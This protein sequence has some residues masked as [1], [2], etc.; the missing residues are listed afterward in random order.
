M[1]ARTWALGLVCSFTG[2]SAVGTTACSSA[3]RPEA[4]DAGTQPVSSTGGSSSGGSGTRSTS[5]GGSSTR[6][7]NSGGSNALSAGGDVTAG[8]ATAACTATSAVDA[9]DNDGVDSNCDGV[10]GNAATSLFVS[11]TGLDSD[12]GT[13]TAPFRSVAHAI[14]I[15]TATKTP[16][17]VLICE[18]TYAENL[19]VK[20]SMGLHGGYDCKT[21]ARTGARPVIAPISGV[22]LRI[23]GV[24]GPMKLSKLTLQ[25]ANAT[26][27]ASSSQAVQIVD[28]KGISIDYSAIVAGNGANGTRGTTP[29]NTWYG[30]APDGQSGE[31][32]VYDAGDTSTACHDM[33]Y[34]KDDDLD[35]YND[36]G[37]DKTVT[38]CTTARA[39]GAEV[40][41]T[42]T[43]PGQS[44]T[45]TYYGGKGGSGAIKPSGASPIASGVGIAGTPATALAASIPGTPGKG[46]GSVTTT[47]YIANNDGGDGATG[48]PGVGGKGGGGGSSCLLRVGTINTTDPYKY[49]YGA[50]YPNLYVATTCSASDTWGG[51]STNGWAPYDENRGNT[52]RSVTMF[53]GSGGGGGGAPGCG[54]VGGFGGKGGGAS[55]AL[56]VS[57]SEVTLAWSDIAAGNGG[58]GGDPSD[59]AAGQPGGSGGKGGAVLVNSSI[60]LPTLSGTQLITEASLKG[61]DGTNGG[62]GQKGTAGGP[63]G[64]GPSIAILWDGT[65]KPNYDST[66]TLKI[67]SGG[68]AGKLI[69][70]STP[71]SAGISADF[72]SVA[73]ATAR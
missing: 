27:A 45:A 30:T 50:N 49:S 70:G 23:E 31:S 17:D 72:I 71:A 4:D 13:R 14:S 2:I 19:V 29:T 38:R 46:F 6:E 65:S 15:A 3:S 36:V 61:K 21:W 56:L 37:S 11:P 66:V 18:G 20:T 25:S 64:G 52:A 35:G 7:S 54:G 16:R 9:P 47:G 10:D 22:A 60:R 55:I 68:L 24:I 40:K 58:T 57:N 53:P 41:V 42:C 48:Q 33:V 34:F 73:D 32:L 63:G 1:L 5:T 59:G 69:E 67:G 8:G 51:A 43:V 12:S 62:Q 44:T 39:G 26:V 28:S